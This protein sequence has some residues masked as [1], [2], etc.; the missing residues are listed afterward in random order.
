VRERNLHH[1]G[2]H[3]V[4]L[5]TLRDLGVLLLCG[6]ACA[7]G[8]SR[9]ADAGGGSS[10]GP[11]AWSAAQALPVPR[12]EGAGAVVGGR[13]LFVGGIT[14]VLDDQLSARESDRVDVYDPATATWSPGPPLPADAPKH[15]LAV[16]VADDVL[17]VLGGFNGILGGADDAGVFTPSAK[18]YALVGTTW[19]RLADQPLARGSAAASVLG[20]TI[21]VAGGGVTEP[22]ALADAYAYD[23]ARDAWEKRAPMP[24]AREHV[25]SCVLGG[26]MIVVGGW[27]GDRTV[28]NAAEAYDPAAD[29]WVSLAPMPT[30]RG[31]LGAAVLDGAC[32][33][34]GGE[35]WTGDL[36]GTYGANE[37]Y[38]PSSNAWTSRAPMPTSRHGLG[39]ATFGDALWAIGGGPVRGNSYT[40]VVEVFRP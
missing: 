1:P 32:W 24:T 10:G 18:S 23:I 6:G 9:A 13:I 37:S 38:D 27:S 20:G 29:R 2:R 35:H 16:A 17:Y 39:V 34:V 15:H 19:K 21:V 40:D 30:A 36:P 33:V 28:V 4:Q 26:K 22:N 7:C 25:A 31:G 5:T 3:E 11:G 8:T 14:G 12:F